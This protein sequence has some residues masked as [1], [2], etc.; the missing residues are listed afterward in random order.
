M[1]VR[2]RILINCD[3]LG[4]HP[5]FGDAILEILGRGIVRSASIMPAAPN[6][7]ESVRRLHGAG[8]DRVGVHLT[9]TSEYRALPIRPLSDPRRI[10]SLIDA[11]GR[12]FAN[13]AVAGHPLEPAEVDEEF[14]SQIERAR[15]AGLRLT[16]LDGHMFCYEREVGGEALLDVARSIA[17]DYGLPLRDRSAR[18]PGSIPRTHMLWREIDDL[19]GRLDFYR[20]FFESYDEPL[21]ELI[22]HPG[23]DL[24]TMQSFSPSGHRRLADYL[25]FRDRAFGDLV[26]SREIEV[27]TWPEV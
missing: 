7:D 12:F 16:H 4:Y 21:S 25:F 24:T 1:A 15:T 18:G 22:I 20:S 3:D 27:I 14:R 17:S 19:E 13:L 26:R 6:F 11:G 9:V 8:I 5:T 2:R 10:A 23:K